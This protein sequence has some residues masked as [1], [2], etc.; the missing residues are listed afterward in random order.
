METIMLDM[1]VT[2]S[3]FSKEDLYENCIIWIDTNI[4]LIKS[5]F[6]DFVNSKFTLEQIE[7]IMK[8]STKGES[9]SDSQTSL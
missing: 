2:I 5:E 8:A 6:S 1:K 4:G 9:K 7:K 3:G